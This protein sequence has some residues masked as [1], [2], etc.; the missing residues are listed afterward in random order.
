MS[1]FNRY[2]IILIVV[3]ALRPDHLGCYGYQR[4]TSPEIDKIAEEG[5][6]F[7][8]VISQSSWTKPAVASLLTSTYPEVH[9]VKKIGDILRYQ[10][11]CLTT[12]LRKNGYVTGCIQTNP[13]LTSESGFGEGFDHY[14]EVFDKSPGVYKPPVQEAIR[15][16]FDWLDHF[17]KDTFFLYLHLLNLNE[18][19][20]KPVG[21]NSAARIKRPFGFSIFHIFL[22]KIC[23]SKGRSSDNIN[24]LTIIS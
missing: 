11:T 21:T 9:G 2:N 15:A 5:V 12:I 17:G 24:L 23:C 14:V 1:F 13:F 3:D 8:R 22:R 7:E 18:C 10:D 6:K 19:F 20:Q 16:A 4:E